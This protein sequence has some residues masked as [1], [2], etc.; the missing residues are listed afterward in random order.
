MKRTHKLLLRIIRLLQTKRQP[1]VIIKIDS[2]HKG[3]LI[4]IEK[5]TKEEIERWFNEAMLRVIK[6]AQEE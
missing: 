4:C 3:D 6:N 1:I 5:M 2:L